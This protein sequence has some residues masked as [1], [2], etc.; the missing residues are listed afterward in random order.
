[1]ELHHSDFKHGNP[2]L[3]RDTGN[4]KTLTSSRSSSATV[5]FDTT[6]LGAAFPA[7]ATS[8]EEH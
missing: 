6:M 3:V 2:A 7:N 5:A 4:K 1:L 8:T